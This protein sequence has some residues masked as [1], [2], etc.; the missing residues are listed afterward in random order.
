[1]KRLASAVLATMVLA[2]GT[3]FGAPVQAA[4]PAAAAVAA[5]GDKLCSLEEWTARGLDE[6]ITRLQDVSA[7]RVQCLSAPNPAAPDSGLGGWF[8]SKPTWTT[9]ADGRS[10]LLYSEYGYAGYDY[11]TYDINCVQTVMHPD[12]KLENTIANGEFMLAAGIVGVSNALRE[13]AWAPDEMWGWADPLVENATTALYRQVFSVFGV[14][15][16]AVIGVYLLWRS[17]Q[18]QMSMALTTVGWAILVM[19]GVTAIAS[20]PVQSA[21][22]ADSTL[23]SV[24]SVVHDAVGPRAQAPT[25]CDDATPGACDDRRPPAVRAGDTAVQAL[26]YRN[27][28]R[29]VLGSADSETAKKY[30]PALYRA[31]SLSWDDV[32]AIQDDSSRRD[33]IIRAKQSDWMKVAEQIKT[34][35][36]EAYEYLRGTK[37]MERVGAGFVAILSAFCY[38]AFDIVASLLVLLGF[39]IIRWAVI[40]AP[41]LGTVGL[42]RPA[43]AGLRRLVNSVLAALFNVL[44]FGTGAAVYLFAVDLI[45]STS[46]LAGWL[47][48]T[49][50]LLCGVVG[51]ILLR[52]YRRITQLGGGSSG[53]SLLTARPSAPTASSSN[54]RTPAPVVAPGSTTSTTVP[55]A[56]PELAVSA[57]DPASVVR[58]EA[59][60]G[61]DPVRAETWRSPDVPESSPA[62]AVYRPATVPHQAATRAEA[63]TE[64]AAEPAQR[65][66]R[67]SETWAER[68]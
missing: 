61:A 9:G 6:C 18:A 28:L 19:V 53:T 45:M 64:P 26:L 2:L 10:Y 15:T 40:A 8:V 30:G 44:I 60:G 17:R 29:G 41:A 32:A 23:V 54:E 16:L 39:L 20:W 12:Y 33:G 4:A 37:G 57:E 36:P 68:S 13:R 46:S 34:E 59:H 49:L 21:K 5:P 27:W 62:Y 48:V 38:A 7:S 25:I 47:Q 31:K 1:M 66:E 35:D 22:A 51:W 55:E 3:L 43:S 50:V 24:L 11:T 63:R 14:I 65:T 52:P 67:R 42:L 58:A 56:R